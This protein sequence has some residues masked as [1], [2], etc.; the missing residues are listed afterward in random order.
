MEEN[1]RVRYL[2]RSKVFVVVNLHLNSIEF[3]MVFLY[4]H[5]F[6]DEASTRLLP[7]KMQFMF[8]E[9]TMAKVC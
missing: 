7:I 5:T 1:A 3:Y 2:R 8:L 4:C 9:V 6:I